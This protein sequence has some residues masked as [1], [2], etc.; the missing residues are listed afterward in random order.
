MFPLGAPGGSPLNKLE[1][2][3]RRQ[4]VGFLSRFS[5]KYGIDLC[6]QVWNNIKM[7]NNN[8]NGIGYGFYKKQ[9]FYC[10]NLL[11]SANINY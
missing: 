2:Y 7:V 9:L 4:G 8:N 10:Y 6:V 3:V 1:M 5:L 11:R